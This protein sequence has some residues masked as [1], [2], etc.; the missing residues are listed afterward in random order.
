MSAGL[1]A[2]IGEEY[3]FLTGGRR[4]FEEEVTTIEQQYMQQDRERGFEAKFV[5][6]PGKN[7]WRR[8]LDSEVVPHLNQEFFS[9]LLSTTRRS[10]DPKGT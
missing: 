4:T 8:W 2:K 9:S 6:E 10:P 7:H 3:E 5:Q 1:V